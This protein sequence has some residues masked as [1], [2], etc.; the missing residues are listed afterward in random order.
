MNPHHF[1][2]SLSQKLPSN[3]LYFFY[4]NVQN[5]KKKSPSSCAL[6]SIWCNNINQCLLKSIVYRNNLFLILIYMSFFLTIFKRFAYCTNFFK[7]YSVSF[8]IHFFITENPVIYIY[9]HIY[10]QLFEKQFMQS[11]VMLLCAF[12]S[13]T[14]FLFNLWTCV[15]LAMLFSIHKRILNRFFPLLKSEKRRIKMFALLQTQYEDNLNKNF[16]IWLNIK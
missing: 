14:L 12:F 4:L 10:I 6:A 15:L 7:D 1:N 5:V 13:H 9:I 16:Q 3:Y 11:H 8:H 2:R